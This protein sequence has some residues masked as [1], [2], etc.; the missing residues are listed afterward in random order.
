[1]SL[2]K[3]SSDRI[4]SGTAPHTL[5]IEVTRMLF[6]LLLSFNSN[7]LSLLSSMYIELLTAIP[8]RMIA[9]T[10]SPSVKAPPRDL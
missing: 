2:L 5:V 3:P 1:M 8:D 7:S 6:N 4:Y 9:A 10:M